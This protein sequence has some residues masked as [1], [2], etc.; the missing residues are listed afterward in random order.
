MEIPWD[1]KMMF[2]RLE[3]TFRLTPQEGESPRNVLNPLYV[4]LGALL[5]NV[6][7]YMPFEVETNTPDGPHGNDHAVDADC[8]CKPS[9]PQK[10][11]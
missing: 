11:K 9:Q 10:A 8:L 1:A 7:K 6:Q 4:L 5:Y 3:V 2:S